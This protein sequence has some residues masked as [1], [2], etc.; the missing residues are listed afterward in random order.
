MSCL[1]AVYLIIKY[2]LFKVPILVYNMIGNIWIVIYGLIG[3]K[4]LNM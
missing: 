4:R 3:I 2:I 1:N